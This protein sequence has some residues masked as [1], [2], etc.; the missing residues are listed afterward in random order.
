MSLL[1]AYK[2]RGG[3]LLPALRDRL[4]LVYPLQ[5]QAARQIVP[6]P[7]DFRVAGLEP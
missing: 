5:R 1:I 4:S 2:L 7:I 6:N 3:P